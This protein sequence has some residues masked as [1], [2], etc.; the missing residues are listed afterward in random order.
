MIR[1]A[2]V[3]DGSGKPAAGPYDIVIEND[4]ITQIVSI[5]P[6]AVKSRAKK[7]VLPQVISR[8]MPPANTF[9]PD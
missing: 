4:I 5:D 3:V 8:S 6:V 7:N 2:T 1:N 9:C